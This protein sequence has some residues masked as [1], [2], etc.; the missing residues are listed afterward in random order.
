MAAALPRATSWT[1]EKIGALTGSELRQLR[2]NAERLHADDIVALCT[3]AIDAGGR[4]VDQPHK[5]R[6]KDHRHLVPRSLAFGMRG[7]ALTN[8]A[9]SRSGLTSQGKVVFA[10]WADD[11]R[12]DRDGARCLLWAPNVDGARPWSDKPGGVERLE[13][14]RIA[15]RHGAASGLM[16]YGTR[17]DGVL[18]DDRA[19]T[20]EGADAGVVIELRVEKHGEEYWARWGT[21]AAA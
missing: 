18:P 21:R 20:V 6:A 17:L 9:W 4:P 1:A 13:H 16:V 11:V 5:K 19:A 14:C 3:Q 15:V 7:V 2:D 12:R 8:P 10:L